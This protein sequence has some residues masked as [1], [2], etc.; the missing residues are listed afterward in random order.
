MSE[1]FRKRTYE[2]GTRCTN[3]KNYHVQRF[4]TADVVPVVLLEIEKRLQDCASC[5]VNTVHDSIVV[6]VHPNE[7]TEVKNCIKTVEK[8]LRESF[9]QYF[10]VDFLIPLVLESKIGR[11]WMELQ[12]CA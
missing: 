8:I 9:L 1:H 5:I 2:Y 7:E 6:D 4:A 10:E 11:N 3:Q 12:K